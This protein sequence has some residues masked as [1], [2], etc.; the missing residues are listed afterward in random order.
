VRRVASA[1]AFI[2]LAACARDAEGTADRVDRAQRVGSSA[3]AI[4]SG[5]DSDATQDSVVL[6][7]HYD[8]LVAGGGTEGCT[9]V[10]LTPELVL[11]ARHCVAITDG[12]AA[13]SEDGTALEGGG[14]QADF[15]PDKLYVFSGNKRPDFISGAAKAARG[16]ELITTGAKTICNNDLAL[17]LLDRQVENAKIA[18]IRLDFPAARGEKV[19]VVGWGLTT[20]TN[21]PETRQTRSDIEIVQ[22]GPARTLGPAE[23]RTG[24]GTCSGDS[25]GPAL[26]VDGAV[27]GVLSRGGNG[28]GATGADNCVDSEL[29]TAENVWTAVINHKDVILS[30]YAKTGQEPWQEGFPNPRLGKLGADCAADDKC[31]SNVCNGKQ[32]S[33]LCDVD[34]CPG[35]WACTDQNGRKVCEQQKEEDGGC[36]TSGGPHAPS[37]W[38]LFVLAGVAFLRRRRR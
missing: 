8:A 25:G 28:T 4:I 16:A 19:T 38:P 32:C 34:P 11:T 31:Q 26:S 22:V 20:T 21:Y 12:S 1:F 35:G 13:C 18:P 10:L 36:S 15:K 17:I 30:A 5:T 23:F 9:G 24:E 7:M 37:S 29:A 33:Q 14:V 27:L 2:F 6:I 3:S